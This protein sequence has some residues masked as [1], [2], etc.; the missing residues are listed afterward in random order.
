MHHNRID[1]KTQGSK[2]EQSDLNS[3]NYPSEKINPMTKTIKFVYE[4]F[5]DS[6]VNDQEERVIKISLVVSRKC[7][8]TND[9]VSNNKTS[10]ESDRMLLTMQSL[11]M[12]ECTIIKEVS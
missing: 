5:I 12:C 7:P 2:P 4:N 11:G 8:K 1:S 10:K 6:S 9:I 3:Q